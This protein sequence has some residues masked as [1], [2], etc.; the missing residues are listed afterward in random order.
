MDK[1]SMFEARRG[2]I[3]LFEATNPFSKCL[4]CNLWKT[5][6][7]LNRSHLYFF[8]TKMWESE[9]R[10]GHVTSFHT[11]I[12][13]IMTNHDKCLALIH[14]AL[15]LHPTHPIRSMGEVKLLS[16][17]SSPTC[18]LEALTSWM[19]HL[20]KRLPVCVRTHVC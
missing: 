6:E 9:N 17:R 13:L 1:R 4:D 15:L 18:N 8:P 7:M 16:A 3:F 14:H 11:V 12:S 20:S 19:E 10:M 5:I 2:W